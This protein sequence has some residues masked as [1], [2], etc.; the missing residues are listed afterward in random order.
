MQLRATRPRRLSLTIAS[1]LAL[2]AGLLTIAQLGADAAGAGAPNAAALVYD[3]DLEDVR[4]IV[5]AGGSRAFFV[6]W[7]EAHGD[8]I[9]TSDGTTEGTRLVADI[10]PGPQSG[11]TYLS[12]GRGVV[13]NGVLYFVGGDGAHGY[14]L[15]RSDGTAAGTSMVKDVVPAETQGVEVESLA[16]SAS[17]IRF[18]AYTTDGVELWRSDGTAAGTV[19]VDDVGTCGSAVGCYRGPM[20]PIS[21]GR[22]LF[23]AGDHVNGELSVTDG[24]AAG[25]QVIGP[26][27]ARN[28]TVS[29]GLAYFVLGHELWR[30][31]GTAA[32]TRRVEGDT[33]EADWPD[34]ITGLTDVAGE[35]FYM[36]DYLAT[37]SGDPY[38]LRR[39]DAS[40]GTGVLVRGFDLADGGY[41]F[42]RPS[43]TVAIG[44]VLYFAPAPTVNFDFFPARALWRSDGTSQGTYKLTSGEA[45]RLGRLGDHLV[46][47]VP[48]PG[49][50]TWS[51][52]RSDGTVAGTERVAGPYGVPFGLVETVRP[53]FTEVAGQL[54]F[55]AGRHLHKLGTDL[56]PPDTQVINGFG[57]GE[58]I[59]SYDASYRRFS[60]AVTDDFTPTAAATYEVQVDGGPWWPAGRHFDFLV[61]DFGLPDNGVHTLAVRAVD[62]AG[63]VDPTPATRTFTI[64]L[65]DG[66]APPPP[67]TATDPGSEVNEVGT[68]TRLR[69]KASRIPRSRR[70]V[71]VVRVVPGTSVPVTGKVV[72]KAGKKAVGSGT[73][74]G[75]R[76]TIKLARLKP[77]RYR[78]S[79]W[80]GGTRVLLPSISA[81][82]TLTVTG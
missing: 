69:L 41:L 3:G 9:W 32:G 56:L 79:A 77:G 2:G 45:Y 30:T 78:I 34:F 27:G 19:K 58:V 7:T 62:A 64:A 36:V 48:D 1:A 60:F 81:K 67:P 21:G 74:A 13:R 33:R 71:A 43:T 44:D 22:H 35:L 49:D 66:P 16:V 4:D 24:T 40:T 25:T 52:W 59:T 15:W 82:K 23:L 50:E 70:A 57:D 68:T 73:L 55:Q 53:G 39:V 76:V 28:I 38:E 47:A 75:G 5:P 26:N 80:Y 8:E 10:W 54:W 11:A 51:A 12:E 46:F 65:P 18:L 63:R 31:D 20:T 37:S 42:A 14:T 6:G 29:N 72:V 61:R 17:G